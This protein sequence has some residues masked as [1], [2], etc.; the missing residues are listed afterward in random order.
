[1]IS[2]HGLLDL[3]AL[4]SPGAPPTDF[5]GIVFPSYIAAVG[6][7]ISALIGGVAL[8]QSFQNKG[9][10]KSLA[11]G[12]NEQRATGIA[13]ARSIRTTPDP[14]GDLVAW[15]IERDG[16][17]YLLVNRS[18]SRTARVTALENVADGR[19]D[20]VRLSETL[21]IDVGP[22]ASL[23]FSVDRNLI[24]ARVTAIRVDWTVVAGEIVD[25][26]TVEGTE[27]SAV[28]FA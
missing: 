7:L 8:F 18:A 21:P 15:A 12:L 13:G 20:A 22:G 27:H 16:R 5:W 24:S 25:G 2:S 10:V 3:V 14:A 1:M 19:R 17:Q 6:G 4:Q 9:S 11:A 28:L 26:T 23:R